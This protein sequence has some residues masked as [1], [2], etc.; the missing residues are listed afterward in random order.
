M[1]RHRSYFKAQVPA[2]THYDGE[3][4]DHVFSMLNRPGAWDQRA[5]EEDE[6]LH[7]GQLPGKLRA[8]CARLCM[9]SGAL[10]SDRVWVL[11]IWSWPCQA[12][13]MY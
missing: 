2:W 9:G 4:L 8:E 5:A 3:W 6:G 10:G 13:Q 12:S 11:E 1:K 7:G